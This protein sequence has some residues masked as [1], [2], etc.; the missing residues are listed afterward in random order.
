MDNIARPYNAGPLGQQRNMTT[1]PA[2]STPSPTSRSPAQPS[3]SLLSPTGN[4]SFVPNVNRV[5][6]MRWV[7]AK[8]HDYDGKDWGE[9]EYDEYEPTP[10]RSPSPPPPMQHVPAKY[11]RPP[12]PVPGISRMQTFDSSQHTGMQRRGSFERGDDGTIQ[13][14]GFRSPARSTTLGPGPLAGYWAGSRS[15]SPM[16]SPEINNE[17]SSGGVGGRLFGGGIIKGLGGL[18]KG[19]AQSPSP[20]P[21]PPA[22]TKPPPLQINVQQHQPVPG[23]SYSP[24]PQQVYQPNPDPNYNPAHQGSQPSSAAS[25]PPPPPLPDFPEPPGHVTSLTERSLIQVFPRPNPQQQ[26]AA[27]VRQHSIA[28]KLPPS[29]AGNS[30]STTPKPMHTP[31]HSADYASLASEQATTAVALNPGS[32]PL[33]TFSV[34]R[35]PSPGRRPAH[36]DRVLLPATPEP[37]GHEDVDLERQKQLRREAERL[38]E[39]QERERIK[40]AIEAE[41]RRIR[42]AEEEDECKRE[43]ERMEREEKAE[44]ERE[45]QMVKDKE[46]KEKEEHMKWVE[47]QRELQRREEEE[48]ERRRLAE[49]EAEE[50][51]LAFEE[52]EQQRIVAEIAKEREEEAERQRLVAEEAECQRLAAEEEE[53]QR[54]AAE[55][56]RQRLAL[57]E[58]ERQRAA[59]E[60]GSE[61]QRLAAIEAERIAEEE[62]AAR[63][64]AIEEEQRRAGEARITEEA[65]LAEVARLEEA[66]KRAA[67]AEAERQ[68][69]TAEE[70]AERQKAAAEQAEQIRRN[71]E[72]AAEEAILAAEAERKAHQEAQAAEEEVEAQRQQNL[73]EKER[74]RLERQRF[75][76]QIYEERRK[77]A[78]PISATPSNVTGLMMSTTSLGTNKASTPAPLQQGVD[79]PTLWESPR[80]STLVM[81]SPQYTTEPVLTCEVE[82]TREED[83]FSGSAGS[84][85]D[86]RQTFFDPSSSAT[87]AAPTPPLQHEEEVPPSHGTIVVEPSTPKEEPRTPPRRA[88]TSDSV[89]STSTTPRAFIRP[90]DMH[91]RTSPPQDR[92]RSP[93]QDRPT[94]LRAGSTSSI[95]SEGHFT[96]EEAEQRRRELHRSISRERVKSEIVRIETM[97]KRSRTPDVPPMPSPWPELVQRSFS[98]ASGRDEEIFTQLVRKPSFASEGGVALAPPSRQDTSEERTEMWA[99]S[100]QQENVVSPIPEGR[101]SRLPGA[102]VT[103]SSLET[104]EE[105]PNK[106]VVS[107][108]PIIYIESKNNDDEEMK[109]KVDKGKGKAVDNYPDQTPAVT[110]GANPREGANGNPPQPK[111]QLPNLSIPVNDVPPPI[112]EKSPR[113]GSYDASIGHII[114]VIT[115]KSPTTTTITSV[116]VQVEIPKH[117][118]PPHRDVSSPTPTSTQPPDSEFMELVSARNNYLDRA[119]RYSMISKGQNPPSRDG[120]SKAREKESEKTIQQGE[121]DIVEESEIVEEQKGAYSMTL[122]PTPLS[123]IPGSVDTTPVKDT[124]DQQVNE[125]VRGTDMKKVHHAAAEEVGPEYASD[126]GTFDYRHLSI[127]MKLQISHSTLMEGDSG[128]QPHGKDDNDDESMSPI[129]PVSALTPQPEAQTER[130]REQ[131]E[132]YLETQHP[133]QEVTQQEQAQIQKEQELHKNTTVGKMLDIQDILQVQDSDQRIK[134]F[135]E[136]RRV[137]ADM[138]TGLQ[139]WIVYAQTMVQGQQGVR[140]HLPQQ[141]GQYLPQNGDQRYQIQIGNGNGSPVGHYQSSSP[142]RG[143]QQ[144]QQQQ[145]QEQQVG[146]GRQVNGNGNA[147]MV[148]PPLAQGQRQSPTMQKPV[149]TTSPIS[150]IGGYPPPSALQQQTKHLQQQVH[151]LQQQHGLQ[152]PP[153]IQVQTQYQTRNAQ[154]QDSLSPVGAQLYDRPMSGA[155]QFSSTEEYQE[156]PKYQQPP[157]QQGGEFKQQEERQMPQ[158]IPPQ[159]QQQGYGQDPQQYQAY[160]QP[161]QGLGLQHSQQEG[162]FQQQPLLQ[163]QQP[164][165]NFQ[166]QQRLPQQRG[167]QGGPPPH[168][169]PPMTHIQQQSYPPRDSRDCRG[170]QDPNGPQP[171]TPQQLPSQEQHSPVSSQEPQHPPQ[172]PALNQPWPP[173]LARSPT[174]LQQQWIEEKKLIK[175]NKNMWTPLDQPSTPQQQAGWQPQQPQQ[176][177]PQQGGA[178]VQQGIYG[179]EGGQYIGAQQPH[180][181]AFS[182]VPEEQPL[183][184]S[185]GK[186]GFKEKT[187]ELLAKFGKGKAKDAPPKKWNSVAPPASK[188]TGPRQQPPHLQ[189][190]PPQQQ[191]QSL[192]PVPQPPPSF[193]HAQGPHGRPPPGGSGDTRHIGPQGRGPA[194]DL[195]HATLSKQGGYVPL[196]SPHPGN[197]VTYAENYADNSNNGPTR[198]FSVADRSQV[199][200]SSISE[201]DIPPSEPTDDERIGGNRQSYTR[202]GAP[203]TSHIQ[204]MH[205]GIPEEEEYKSEHGRRQEQ[206]VPVLPPIKPVGT[207]DFNREKSER[208]ES[209]H[210]E[211]DK[212]QFGMGAVEE[213]GTIGG[214]PQ[215][216][217]QQQQVQ[218]TPEQ[219]GQ[220]S[221][222]SVSCQPTTAPSQYEG[223]KGGASHPSISQR[224]VHESDVSSLH[225]NPRGTP[226]PEQQMGRM[227]PG[228]A[229]GVGYERN[230]SITSQT[231][232]G[233]GQS[234]GTGSLRTTSPAPMDQQGFKSPPIQQGHYRQRS[235]DVGER[236]GQQQY[237]P[238]SQQYQWQGSGN[239]GQGLGLGGPYGQQQPPQQQQQDSRQTPGQGEYQSFTTPTANQSPAVATPPTQQGF[240]GQPHEQHQIHGGHV[241]AG[242]VS[243]FSTQPS[244]VALRDNGSPQM[245]HGSMGSASGQQFIQQHNLT[246]VDTDDPRTGVVPQD[247]TIISPPQSQYGGSIYA[248]SLPS[249]PMATVPQSS[250]GQPPQLSQG[251]PPR[252]SSPGPLRTALAMGGRPQSPS[253]GAQ[254]DKRPHPLAH[255]FAPATVSKKEKGEGRRVSS[256]FGGVLGTK[257]GKGEKKFS[258][259]EVGNMVIAQGKLIPLQQ[260]DRPGGSPTHP[261]QVGTPKPPQSAQSLPP[262]GGPPPPGGP[263]PPQQQPQHQPGVRIPKIYNSQTGQYETYEEVQARLTGRAPPQS[264]NVPATGGILQIAP[265]EQHHEAVPIPMGYRTTP[266]EYVVPP[267]QGRMPPQQIQQQQQRP[268]SGYQQQPQGPQDRQS[269]APSMGSGKHGPSVPPPRQPG[270]AGPVGQQQSQSNQY[271]L[272]ESPH[273]SISATG[274]RR[275]QPQAQ[276][277][278]AQYDITTRQQENEPRPQRDPSQRAPG[279]PVL[280][281]SVRMRGD[282]IR[283]E[284]SPGV[285]ASSAGG[286]SISSASSPQM[287]TL[288][289]VSQQQPQPPQQQ[290]PS[291]VFASSSS[292][293][294]PPVTGP[295][296]SP[297]TVPV[298]SSSTEVRITPPSSPSMATAK[299][300]P[301]NEPSGPP[302]GVTLPIVHMDYAD[303][304]IPVMDEPEKEERIIMSATSWPGM[305][306]EPECFWM[307]D[308]E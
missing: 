49:E 222:T 265:G 227:V 276:Q 214:E 131:R 70:E 55:E 236:Y 100:M 273:G 81:G 257:G 240:Q 250:H 112:G 237:Q 7:Q 220:S 293:S 196:V 305:G 162:G 264:Q 137:F 13:P 149:D 182:G 299:K 197:L 151:N 48:N 43:E 143:T 73:A 46:R 187:K 132:G 256:F 174:M 275:S 266:G 115:Q 53:R 259:R 36:P 192:L 28:R 139:T 87:S 188:P 241:R 185:M 186:H 215:A 285:G 306:W 199:S 129:S 57:R 244:I 23:R 74:E 1:S 198:N 200:A 171:T 292:T 96:T 128:R 4:P 235:S 284:G 44:I 60:E 141:Q 229:S 123:P 291:F 168:Q 78:T 158:Q 160:L 230:Y 118:P 32:I 152:Q 41:M 98:R 183:K 181:D 180:R 261:G 126:D 16:L 202:S 97:K 254:E 56:E 109:L 121:N 178:Q 62:K 173:Q 117:K 22:Y 14:G 136:Q 144:P 300:Y 303:E 75:N 191:Q 5:K 142:T 164:P 116:R 114:P 64:V 145:Q 91:A 211:G 289:Q 278:P 122:M 106:D 277:S 47:E 135:E 258:L 161:G 125:R 294:P 15:S 301:A 253:M 155:T 119:E 61:W 208:V 20:P 271:D 102:W 83:L 302:P 108:K 195:S 263:R 290:T 37:R 92:G 245:R 65:R 12:P 226:Q 2:P 239:V 172:A 203:G 40:L 52:A 159:Q 111:Y 221:E 280:P 130:E 77:A 287:I 120:G 58:A 103:D 204:G 156:G 251:Y 94:L 3:S 18:I 19:G 252:S 308:A 101:R 218:G 288:S 217:Q 6:S 268:M 169:K 243:S 105:V 201:S 247:G 210:G 95:G 50:R 134:T 207:L 219:Q 233:Q 272:R 205:D 113:R 262:I 212:G 99:R 84:E 88:M 107:T 67:E 30:R 150:P 138:D 68:R 90:A 170:P 8:T 248:P 282:S 213:E 283:R 147:A 225:S 110:G 17:N 190:P 133:F 234:T 267:G 27:P 304:K 71:E 298:A 177:P 79:S 76:Q 295:T 39:E 163:Q 297:A 167:Y 25:T 24:S 124:F 80:I 69:V 223:S 29:S 82:Q 54:L 206:P 72:Q 194:L 51:H 281:A 238:A 146:W 260:Q 270:S 38:E 10:T 104:P 21:P 35:K 246:R 296:P 269:P 249:S 189:Q 127:P 11:Y 26:P 231:M 157:Q 232:S 140:Q 228:G 93:N 42:E 59:E 184:H 255:S 216:A 33:R 274:A 286:F 31:V 176:L 307:G 279:D 209:R 63:K 154:Q 193:S 166:D 242:S 86:I 45:Q 179:Q 85:E 148:Q 89:T 175:Q 9:D 66:E 153:Q 34:S 165:Q 224:S